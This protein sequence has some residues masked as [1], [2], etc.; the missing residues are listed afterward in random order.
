MDTSPEYIKQCEKAVEIQR[1]ANRGVKL[2]PKNYVYCP[3]H[4]NLITMIFGEYECVE[5]PVKWVRGD[6]IDGWLWLPTQD[7]LQDILVTDLGIA[8]QISFMLLDDLFDWLKT[9]S[10]NDKCQIYSYEQ[11]WL[12]FVMFS[13]YGKTWN[14]E[15]WISEQ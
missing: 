1:M 3:T 7:Q 9:L 4:S 11:L 15:D 6:S 10:Y 14:G 13:K 2:N 8:Y 5:C 12:A